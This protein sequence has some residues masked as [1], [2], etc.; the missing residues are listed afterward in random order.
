MFYID[1]LSHNM[2]FKSTYLA[3]QSGINTERDSNFY[4]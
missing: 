4:M 3:F 1:L 2:R